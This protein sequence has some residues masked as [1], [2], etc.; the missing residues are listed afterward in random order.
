MEITCVNNNKHTHITLDG[1]IDEK[2]ADEIKASFKTINLASTKEVTIDCHQVNHIGSSGIGK[3]L[4]LYKHLATTGG[5]LSVT[6]L[7]TDMFELFKELKL[8][9]LFTITQK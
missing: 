1:T 4:L 7:Q 5:K 9:T 2:G 3:I 6:N 8:D